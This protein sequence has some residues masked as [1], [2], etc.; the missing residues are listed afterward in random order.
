MDEIA[1]AIGVG[2]G[3]CGNKCKTLI[4]DVCDAYLTSGLSYWDICACE[5][6][7]RARGGAVFLGNMEKI[8]YHAGNHHINGLNAFRTISI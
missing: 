4:E 8:T 1:P 5:P 6:L 7:V 3:G 2:L